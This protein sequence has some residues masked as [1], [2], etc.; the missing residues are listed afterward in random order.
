MIR[1]SISVQSNAYLFRFQQN[2]KLAIFF[3]AMST[4]LSWPFAAILGIPIA[5][6]ILLRRQKWILFI[7]WSVISTIILLIPQILIDSYYY[8]K[9]TIASLNI[10][11]YNVWNDSSNLYGTEPW[12]YYL[13]NGFLNF[14]FIFI[15]AL[16]V[17]P[18]QLVLHFSVNIPQRGTQ[19]L[20]CILSQVC[21]LCAIAN[22][23]IHFMIAH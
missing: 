11:M 21:K 23:C 4:F 13:F 18:L 3:T 14:N 5:I 10:V 16:L 8:G 9:L 22:T 6:D 7:K 19:Y 12:T 2:Y 17:W 20:P 1:I 15:A